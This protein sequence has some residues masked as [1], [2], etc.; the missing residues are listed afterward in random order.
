MARRNAEACEPAANRR[1]L[2]VG[3]AVE[4]IASRDTR[5]EQPELLK[6]AGEPLLDPG[7]L[8]E[9]ALVELGLAVTQA[10]CAAAPALR[11]GRLLQ[12][13]ADHLQRQELVPLQP[14]DRLQP[15]ELLL[16][17]EAVPAARPLRRHEPLPLEVADL[18]DRDVGELAL[19][20]IADRTDRQQG[21]AF[22]CLSCR[23]PSR[24]SSSRS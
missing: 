4:A 16:A 2:G 18:R 13:L 10:A 12:L 5:R 9:G 7:A 11:G 21:R 23:H 22:G 3:L 24:L 20:A 19:E 6:L 15:F 17:E 14:Q 1:D 8:A